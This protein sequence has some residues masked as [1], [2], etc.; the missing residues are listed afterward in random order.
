MK[1]LIASDIHGNLEYMQK[2]D[3][4]CEKEKFDKIILLGDLLHNY[5]YYNQAEENGV[6]SL[7]NKRAN[8]TISVVGN[9]D[10][11]YEIDKLL[12]PVVN[13]ID[14]IDL[15]EHSFFIT[16]GHLNYKYR[17]LLDDNYAFVGHTHIYDLSDKHINPGSVGLP[18]N[19]NESTCLI[20]NNHI[21]SI[22][23]LDTGEILAKKCLK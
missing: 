6:A 3:K 5:Y 8:I 11:D 14:K 23:S 20:Y 15:D 7:L 10:R 19:H 16:H 22:I 12:F 1:A 21:L 4:I 2:L 13:E 9:C 17:Y 18:R